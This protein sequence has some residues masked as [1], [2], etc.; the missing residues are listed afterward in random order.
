MCSSDLFTVRDI[1][2]EGLQRVEP[3]TVFVSL[4]LQVGDEYNDEKGAQAIR[5]L[6]GLGL[7][8][9][10]RIEVNGDV[11]VVVVQ[12]RPTLAAVTFVGTKEF[13]S[14]ALTKALKDIGL[15]DGRAFDQALL[16]RAEQEL[17]RQYIN[18]GL[19]SVS[20]VTTV[21][22]IERNR[23]NLSFNVVEGEPARITE[24]RIVGNKAFDQATLLG[25]FDQ[26]TGGWLS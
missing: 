26:D 10:V 22:P 6:F 8:K 5:S 23:V 1:R 18:R 9:D 2:I 24:I 25:Q 20:V 11:L 19:Y 13:D 12:E 7:F 3:G 16:D 21:T 15:A 4:P 17:K 14:E